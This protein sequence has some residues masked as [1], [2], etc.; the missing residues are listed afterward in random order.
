MRSSR[1]RTRARR[2][3]TAALDPNHAPVPRKSRSPVQEV[4]LTP[5][6]PIRVRREL[7]TRLIVAAVALLL[8][9]GM[10]WAYYRFSY[11]VSR[12]AQVKGYITQ[13]GAQLHGVVTSIEVDA[14]Q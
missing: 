2:A 9:P 6:R 8:V 1:E 14:G 5:L 4:D 7:R 13:I 10:I 11:V 12:N 3:L